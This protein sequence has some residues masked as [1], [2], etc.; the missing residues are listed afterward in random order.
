MPPRAASRLWLA[1]AGVALAGCRATALEQSTQPQASAPPGLAGSITTAGL[2]AYAVAADGTVWAWGD[3]DQG[4]LGVEGEDRLLPTR[5]AVPAALAV[6][7][8]ERTT[9]ARTGAHALILA[10]DGTVHGV[11]D[12]DSSQLG[13]ADGQDRFAPQRVP[14][15]DGVT[16]LAAGADFS[17]ALRTDG[18]IWAWGTDRHGALGDGEA[19]RALPHLPTAITGHTG[20]QSL[21]AGQRHVLALRQDGTVL[22]WGGNDSG[23][24][25]DGTREARQVP[26]PVPGLKDVTA[27][28]A[29]AEFSMALTRDGQVWT[30]GD[31]DDGELGHKGL[32]LHHEALSPQRVE[33]LTEVIAIAAGGGHALALRR[34]GT[35]WGWGAN[36]FG[37][38]GRGEGR[39]GSLGLEAA[40]VQGLTG[41]AAIA[42]GDG[43]SL[44]ARADGT[45]WAWGANGNGQL[46][47]GTH[48]F[49]THPVPVAVKGPD[50]Q[51]A[52]K[53]V[54]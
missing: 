23:Q 24:L 15:L 43:F 6:A 33:R 54:P 53:L 5:L 18:T 11:G 36:H 26:V 10:R 12:G 28:A 35:A 38:L 31:N 16:H 52:L 37:E 51:G 29:G 49:E 48:D 14:G 2:A 42:A 44:A 17:L 7:A 30:W 3:N 40:P 1:L 21:A 13:L 45:V 9:G 25:G 46:G 8:G 27:I 22:A 32:A 47:I 50:G 20:V 4:E 41:V 39:P 19:T 34:D